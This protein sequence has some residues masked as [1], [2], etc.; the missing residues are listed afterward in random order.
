MGVCGSVSEQIYN[1][2]VP[3]FRSHFLCYFFTSPRTSY[4]KYEEERKTKFKVVRKPW[5]NH[6]AKRINGKHVLSETVDT[7][8]NDIWLDFKTSPLKSYFF[9]SA[10]QMVFC[11]SEIQSRSCSL[12][13]LSALFF[14]SS[15]ALVILNPIISHYLK[16]K[17]G[18]DPF[19]IE[20]LIYGITYRRHLTSEIKLSQCLNSFKRILIT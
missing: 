13:F 7:V 10:V 2:P 4:K 15:R 18:R 20:L 6:R 11:P 5:E 19:L 8:T 17:Q 3:F 12:F 14:L 1:F 16:L 9:K